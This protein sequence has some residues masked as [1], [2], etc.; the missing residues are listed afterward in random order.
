MPGNELPSGRRR[1]VMFASAGPAAG[2]TTVSKLLVEKL[3]E[4][5]QLAAWVPDSALFDWP[6]LADLADAFR[7]RR[8]PGP[9]LLLD[10]LSRLMEAT[11]DSPW[12][13]F[14]TNWLLIA[15]DLAWA[16]AS[17]GDLVAFAREVRR[18]IS[19]RADAVVIFLDLDLAEALERQ[20]RRDGDVAFERWIGYMR[21]LPALGLPPDAAPIEVV[22][23]W[24]CRLAAL[25]RA[26]G[27][28]LTKV[29]A[30]G[31][32]DEVLGEVLA[33]LR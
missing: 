28:A 6:E 8:Y 13:V 22:R 26:S 11:A 5:G 27:Q 2:K 15:E 1:V 16:Q 21:R 3:A 25:W 29:S 32:P 20:R 18:L 19:A 31:T 7:C 14:E 33:G 4:W 10:G 24:S 17:W 12:V 23:S 30:A 9:E